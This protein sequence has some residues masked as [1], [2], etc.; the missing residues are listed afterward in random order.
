[1]TEIPRLNG[2]IRALAKGNPAFVTF[3]GA[4]VTMAQTIS[5]APYDGVVFEMEH[6]PL[7]IARLRDCL[8]YMLDRRELV[9]S[10]TLAP[11]VT[12]FVRIPPNGGELNQWIAKQALDAGVYG[13]VWPHVST[14]EEARN[15]VA[16]CRYPRPAAAPRF[17]P[18]GVRGDGPRSA[19]RYWGLTPA[20]YYHRADV[21]PLDPHG[22]LLVVIMCEE[23]RAIKNLPKMLEDVPG[24]GV[25]LIGEGDLSQDLGFP[26]QYDHPSVATAIND[27]LAICKDHEIPCGHP[28]VDASNVEMLLDRGFRWLML[29]PVLSF[30]ALELGRTAAQTN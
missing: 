1:M 4:D 13:I 29:S 15:A 23:A 14:V 10:A 21:W 17:N 20:E 3:A 25:V 9:R 5:A 24:I 26:R 6:N 30:S 7:D 2:V 11:A 19:S 12:P 27:I 28:H 18:A 8:Q 22:E 16:A